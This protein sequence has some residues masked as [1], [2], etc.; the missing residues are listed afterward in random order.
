MREVIGWPIRVWLLIFILNFAI[1][2]A[3]GVALTD[4]EILI[5]FV[6][7][8]SLI[9]LLERKTRLTIV[10][11][12]SGISVNRSHIEKEFISG[13]QELSEREMRI[14]RG[15]G[16][17]SL[18]YI[19]IR[20]WVKG[21]IKIVLNDPRDPTPYWLVSTRRAAEIRGLLTS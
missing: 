7:L 17:N 11:N 1:L 19:A 3:V 2:L 9:V 6:A 10:V 14:E 21:G 13:I 4:R 16:L 18:A 8:T 12:S 5:L 15:V 20:F